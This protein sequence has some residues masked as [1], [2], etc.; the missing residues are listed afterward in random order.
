MACLKNCKCK[1]PKEHANTFNQQKM[2]DNAQ[3]TSNNRLENSF[4]RI[5]HAQ[6][7]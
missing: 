4:Q 7:N 5:G 6:S 3:K 2:R 1:R